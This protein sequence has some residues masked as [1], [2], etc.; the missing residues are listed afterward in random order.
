MV[1]K[2]I[3]KLS[4]NR[5]RIHTTASGLFKTPTNPYELLRTPFSILFHRMKCY[6]LFWPPAC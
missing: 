1:H 4:G 3:M 5:A 6:L 2:G